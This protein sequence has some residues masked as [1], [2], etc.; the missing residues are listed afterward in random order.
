MLAWQHLTTAKQRIKL[1][2]R[3]LSLL[4]GD[5]ENSQS[6]FYRC[7]MATRKTR[8]ACFTADTMLC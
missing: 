1:A 3:V 5:E 8:K 6:V 2:E 7:Y 4:Y